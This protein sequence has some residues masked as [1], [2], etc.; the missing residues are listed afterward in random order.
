ML[1]V[2]QNDRAGMECA[3]AGYQ[4]LDALI[5]MLRAAS[6]PE[7]KMCLDQLLEHNV[8]NICL[9]ARYKN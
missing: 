5:H 1:A 7:R 8:V 2:T 6:V 9:E 3:I 4:A